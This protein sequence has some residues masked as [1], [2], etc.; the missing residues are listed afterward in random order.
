MNIEEIKH[1]FLKIKMD[2][3]GYIDSISKL[4]SERTLSSSEKL[5]M[6]RKLDEYKDELDKLLMKIFDYIRKGN[7]DDE[8]LDKIIIEIKVPKDFLSSL[9]MD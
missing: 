7:L 3:L 1:E 5:L 9:K 6:Y 4:S 2:E 8:E